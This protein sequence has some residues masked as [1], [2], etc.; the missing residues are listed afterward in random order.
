M[1]E[2]LS[3]LEN[4]LSENKKKP[5]YNPAR[6]ALKQSIADWAELDIRT[7]RKYGRADFKWELAEP[8]YFNE[9]QSKGIF[10]TA[11]I[12]PNK[13]GEMATF[14]GE[15]IDGEWFFFRRGLPTFTY[16]YDEDLRE[17]EPYTI[18]EIIGYTNEK[19]VEDGLVNEDGNIDYDYVNTKWFEEDREEQHESFL[20]G[21]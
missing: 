3:T 5:A 18:K 20:Q 11:Y 17:G 12:K 7:M 19:F 2:A 1:T 8:V 14:I 15:E 4:Y 6:A 9:D 21:F 10:F 16:G 13:S